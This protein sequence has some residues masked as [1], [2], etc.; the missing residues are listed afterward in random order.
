[1]LENNLIKAIVAQND[2]ARHFQDAFALSLASLDANTG[3]AINNNTLESNDVS[4]QIGCNDGINESDVTLLGNTIKKSSDG[5][6]QI[7]PSDHLTRGYVGVEA[8]L[9][10][11]LVHN[12]RLIDMQ[13]AGGAD[14]TIQFCGT[15]SKDVSSG[16]ALGITVVDSTGNPVSGA[17]VTI[18]DPNGATDY[19]GTTGDSGRITV[20][21]LVTTTS[22]AASVVQNSAPV[23]TTNQ[24]FTVTANTGTKSGNKSITLTGDQSVQVQVQ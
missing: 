19:S 20:I 1:V 10:N 9:Y 11:G 5:I 3:L 8:G 16:Y 21:P 18:T 4:L 14:S 23:V 17:A 7:R 12:I 22:T 6:T 15:G 13:Y 24:A 2:P